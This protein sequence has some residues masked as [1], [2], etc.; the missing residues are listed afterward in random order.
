[1]IDTMTDGRSTGARLLG[2]TVLAA[3]VALVSTVRH[4]VKG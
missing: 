4:P 1:M 2:M 3:L